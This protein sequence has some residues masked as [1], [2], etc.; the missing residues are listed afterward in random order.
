MNPQYQPNNISPI[1]SKSPDM[2]PELIDEGLEAA[3]L[4]Y[5]LLGTTAVDLAPVVHLTEDHF[6]GNRHKRLWN[7]IN[8]IAQEGLTIDISSVKSTLKNVTP[9]GEQFLLQVMSQAGGSP[10]SYAK[11][12]EDLQWR[13]TCYLDLMRATALMNRPD[14]SSDHILEELSGVMT[15]LQIKAAAIVGCASQ[16]LPE[17]TKEYHDHYLNQDISGIGIPT[18]FSGLD[19]EINGLERGRVYVIAAETG[20]GKSTFMQN[21][22]QNM[23]RAGMRGLIYSLELPE[24][25]YMLRAVSAESQID[26]NRI[27]QRRLNA[28]EVTRFNESMLRMKEV[29]TP[30]HLVYRSTPSVAQLKAKIIELYY[31]QGIDFVAIDYVAARMFASDKTYKND[32]V[33][34]LGSVS[35]TLSTLAKELNIIIFPLVQTSRE[36]RK[37]GGAPQN[38]DLSGASALEQDADVILQLQD[39]EDYSAALGYGVTNLHITKSRTGG[40]GHVVKLEARKHLFTF[41]TWRD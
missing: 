38:E 33:G 24:K 36:S 35:K 31:G 13:R 25:E 21:I 26:L 15:Q 20:G 41:A 29:K 7:V 8:R 34:F 14:F 12:L 27:K 4:G 10:A 30:L 16:Q 3:L 22:A 28:Q 1:P 17:L 2:P 9:E 19:T 23:N 32:P 11:M 40:E 5:F 6:Y 39:S 18:G 37:R